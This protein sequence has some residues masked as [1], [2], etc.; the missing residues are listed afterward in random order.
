M[1]VTPQL[2]SSA[3]QLLDEALELDA[4]ARAEWLDRL[5]DRDSE[6]AALVRRLLDA[7]AAGEAGSEL[8]QLP[9]LELANNAAAD[10]APGVRIGP[11][12]LKREIAS[13]GMADVW[14]AERV[15]G[16]FTREVALK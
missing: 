1:K 11:Y 15:D 16:A 3:S 4:I 10:S 8:D 2:W 6:L 13:G 5:A 14:V 7:H 12:E 9:E